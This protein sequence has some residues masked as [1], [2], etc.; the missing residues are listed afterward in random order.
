MVRYIRAIKYSW[1]QQSC[2][3]LECILEN[4]NLKEAI[5][6]FIALKLKNVCKLLLVFKQIIQQN[7][8]KLQVKYTEGKN[9][10]NQSRKR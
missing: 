5:G 7:L 1:I 3:L 9:H 2:R 8:L 4:R 6:K 10:K